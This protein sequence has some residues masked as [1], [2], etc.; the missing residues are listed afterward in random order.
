[1]KTE[2]DTLRYLAADA[3][4]KFAFLLQDQ[5]L[6]KLSVFHRD[7]RLVLDYLTTFYNISGNYELCLPTYSMRVYAKMH[8]CLEL[9]SEFLSKFQD[10]DIK[11]ATF[12]STVFINYSLQY[13]E[14]VEKKYIPALLNIA[15]KD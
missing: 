9:F 6:D 15:D 4:I 13:H 14:F 3:A 8:N 7:D 1:M 5:K 10:E 11:I 12:T 2:S